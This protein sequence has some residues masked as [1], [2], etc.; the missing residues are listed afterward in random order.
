MAPPR[1]TG[2]LR[3]NNPDQWQPAPPPVDEETPEP[4]GPRVRR[5]GGAA[6]R[7]QAAVYDV[8]FRS[9]KE[10]DGA[11]ACLEKEPGTKV[12]DA[13]TGSPKLRVLCRTEA[14]AALPC[15]PQAFAEVGRR[16]LR[17]DTARAIVGSDAP[18]VTVESTRTP[19]TGLG[20]I[21]AVADSGFD[22]AHPDFPWSRIAAIVA[23]GRPGDSSD[24]HGHGTHVAGTI[25]GDGNAS[26]AKL[27]GVAPK[28]KLYFQSIMDEQGDLGGLPSDLGELLGPAYDAGARIHNDSWGADLEGRYTTDAID[29]DRFV[30]EH[31][32]ML[33]VIAAG[34]AGSVHPV[35]P[36]FVHVALPGQDIEWESIGS[37]ASSKNALVVGAS[38]TTRRKGGYARYTHHEMWPDDFPASAGVSA[39]TISGDPQALA[40]F[41]SRGPTDDRRLKPD[42]VA[43]GTDILSTRSVDAPNGNFWGI[44]HKDGSHYAYMGGTSMA[45][46]HVAGC[47]ALVREYFRKRRQPRWAR[48]SAALIKATL[49][50]GAQPLTAHDAI[51]TDYP[52]N[53]NMH[54]GF[55][56]VSIPRSIPIDG[57]FELAFVDTWAGGDATDG[58]ALA[59]GD[60]HQWALDLTDTG[61]LRICLAYTDEPGRSIQNVLD[62]KVELPAVASGTSTKRRGN[63][64]R[65]TFYPGP[66]RTNNV[67]VVRL[68]SAPA[69]RYVIEVA[70]WSVRATKHYALVVTGA[71][72][73]RSGSGKAFVSPRLLRRIK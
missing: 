34:N 18:E 17:N 71:L 6:A 36:A 44:R 62:L 46:P 16:R 67:A 42:L 22:V 51:A 54:Q 50:N 21:V 70:P 1:R 45:A 41:S 69:G 43:P 7:G 49:I 38:R 25:L 12:I 31:P 28:A 68:E 61:P 26:N 73:R 58:F 10:R 30:A 57:T 14:L 48:P 66:D 23:L 20:E 60:V 59:D 72:K 53:P 29:V 19:L 52:G 39:E 63:D 65:S 64:R 37:P 2:K 56:C 24:F 35:D 33:V 8:V 40:G 4:G 32:D 9:V 5:G 15:S 47:A 13:P 27:R 11:R 55:G 3:L